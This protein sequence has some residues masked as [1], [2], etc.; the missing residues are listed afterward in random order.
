MDRM[1]SIE[2]AMKNEQAEK[3]FYLGHA[4]RTRNAVARI[5]F[6]AL[7][8]DEDEHKKRLATLYNKLKSDGAWPETVPIEVAGTDVRRRLA[9]AERGSEEASR[10]DGDDLDALRKAE[11]FEAAGGALYG[12]LAAACANPQ[13]KA[14][15]HFLAGIERE[16]LLSVRDSIAYLED[17]QGWLSARERSG[18]DGA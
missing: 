16:H 14:F 15:F 11:S 6:E 10:H 5:L 12:N 7:A 8:A 3:E 9:A 2:L 18:L 17:P 1:S 13:E 4:K